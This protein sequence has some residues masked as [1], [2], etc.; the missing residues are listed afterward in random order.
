MANDSKQCYVKLPVKIKPLRFRWKITFTSSTNT[1]N[2]KTTH[3]P[4]HIRRRPRKRTR[5]KGQ[6]PH[7]RFKV[8]IENKPDI[9]YPVP[10][11][12]FGPAVDIIS[13]DNDHSYS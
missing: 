5:N 11:H 3:T 2:R 10:Y 12:T 4:V 1:K 6:L 13:N 9:L 7:I 8:K